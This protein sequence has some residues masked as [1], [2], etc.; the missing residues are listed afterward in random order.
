MGRGIGVKGH[1]DDEVF[2]GSFH[3]GLNHECFS[4]SLSAVIHS[5]VSAK[6]DDVRLLRRQAFE[7]LLQS[8]SGKTATHNHNPLGKVWCDGF[9]FFHH[10][11]VGANP[12]RD[13]LASLTLGRGKMNGVNTP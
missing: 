13:T 12:A 11:M 2:D 6:D 7:T 8:H 4:C 10:Q 5:I 9:V 1:G 3:I